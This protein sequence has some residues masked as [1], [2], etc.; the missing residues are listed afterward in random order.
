MKIIDIRCNMKL[1]IFGIVVCMVVSGAGIVDMAASS[2][3]YP[4]SSNINIP[5]RTSYFDGPQVIWNKTYGG[6]S[7][8]EGWMVQHINNRGYI[9]I[10]YTV[11]Y[12]SGSADIWL[13][14]TDAE[15]NQQWSKTYGGRGNDQ[16]RAVQQTSD[17]GYIIGA[18]TQSFGAG[19]DDIWVI[20]TDASGNIVWQKT[21]GGT[22][23]DHCN[24]ILQIPSGEY[25]LIGDWDLGGTS[26]LLV[27][28]LDSEGNELWTRVYSGDKFGFG[29]S[30]QM[31][32]D[33]GFILLGGINLYGDSDM[34]L[35]KTDANGI[36]MW[37]KTFGERTPETATSVIQTRDNGFLLGGWILPS[38]LNKS[39]LL[40]KTDGEGNRLWE[41]KIEAGHAKEP[42]TNTLG[43]DETTDGSYIVAG[44]KIVSNDKNAWVIKTDVNGNILWDMTI[45]GLSDEYSCGIQQTNDENF[46]VV[47]ATKSYGVGGYDMWLI[48]VSQ[49]NG[50]LPPLKPT[51]NGPASGTV[52]N[53]YPYT[54]STTDPDG[55]Q[56]YYLWDWGDGNSSGWL[57]PYNSGATC[58][59]NHTWA[60]KGGYN[61]KVKAKDT[62]GAESPWSDPLSITMPYSYKPILQFLKLL[63]ERFPQAFLVVRQLLG[64]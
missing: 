62:F 26:D 48:K 29:H 6:V 17:G 61:I 25:V 40:I 35:I 55:D 41:K 50:T 8:D 38:D 1:C 31:T 10:G 46:I 21:F 52:N 20:K 28:K 58:E 23:Q 12:G 9:L 51:I 54:S 49:G 27:M 33:G 5:G 44:E 30:I 16:S 43:L 63:I 39:I 60:T 36:M 11:S 15:G 22:N 64:Y 18:T 56:V 3:Q 19:G 53:E 59:S 4:A 37:D 42:Y 14:K 34:W 7:T 13:I 57:G 47:G 24:A 32:S 45:G 2:Y